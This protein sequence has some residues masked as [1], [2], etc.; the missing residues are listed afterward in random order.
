MLK[1]LTFVGVTALTA[2]V[3]AQSLMVQG[4]RGR[5][6]ARNPDG[7]GHFSM[8][9]KKFTHGNE[10]RITGGFEFTAI[11]PNSNAG[12]RVM[13][14]RAHVYGQQ[15]N[16]AEFSGPAKLVRPSPNGPVVVEGR[17]L[18]R[19][20]DNRDPNLTDGEDR[21]RLRFAFLTPTAPAPVVTF[22][23]NVAHGD[24]NVYQR[25]N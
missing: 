9:V 3:L 22:E 23:G 6:V 21:D 18:V 10:T 19:V 25:G 11:T 17:L 5:G 14:R 12:F 4:A 16:A 24:I 13:M 7:G 2:A 1:K 20:V 15:D 8:D